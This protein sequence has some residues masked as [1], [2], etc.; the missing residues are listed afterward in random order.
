MSNLFTH[1]HKRYNPLTDEWVLVS[2][3]R[4]QRPW[5]GKVEQTPQ[6]SLPAYDPKCY[7][8]PGNERAGGHR[9]PPYK[10]M[11]VFDNDFSALLIDA[12]KAT[13]RKSKLI[14]A[15]SEKGICRV[16][17]YSPRHDL[18]MAELPTS[19]IE[20]VVDV[21]TKEYYELCS[22]KE[23][24]H[25]QIF[26]NKGAIM[27]CSNPHPHGQIW[28]TQT[29]PT[30]PA[31]EIK[32]QK[33][34]ASANGGKCLLCEYL[35]LELETKE[36][37]ICSNDEW[38][39]LIPFWA[40]WPFETMVL[41][42]NHV[43]DLVAFNNKQRQNLADI[44]KKITTR[45]DNLFN[46]SFP[47]TMGLHQAPSDYKPYDF[48]HFHIHF[49]PPLLRSATVQKFMVGFEMMANAQRDIT[50]EQAAE[51]LRSLPEEHFCPKCK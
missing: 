35:K 8:C 46:V 40:K 5:Q 45:Y 1:P 14:R 29:I 48:L 26:E 28:A 24:A 44:L 41:P 16:I 36:R 42:K 50:P 30:E 13:L 49:Y 22:R 11:F 15:Q 33:N 32:S 4:L 2:P 18:T 25:V 9:N 43:K 17:C 20:N 21:W 12:P 27:G 10:N 19:D 38:I 7:L 6:D 39:A 31:R 51:R 23:I 34:Y 3:H 47:Y 37:I